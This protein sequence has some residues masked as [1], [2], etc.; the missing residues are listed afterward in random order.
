MAELEQAQ[1][2]IESVN[3]I[4][5]IGTND[6]NMLEEETYSIVQMQP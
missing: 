4:L 6:R 3:R 1:V 2:N 5:E